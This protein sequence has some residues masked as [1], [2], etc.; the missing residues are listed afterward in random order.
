MTTCISSDWDLGPQVDQTCRHFDFTLLFEA[1]FLST[2]PSSILLVSISVRL[3]RVMRASAKVHGG[4]L[5]PCKTVCDFAV[6]KFAVPT[7]D[8]YRL[9]SAC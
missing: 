4:I 8:S 2:L 7:D 6:G 5:L 1:V 9:A 3:W